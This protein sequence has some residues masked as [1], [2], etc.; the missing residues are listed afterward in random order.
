MVSDRRTQTFLHLFLVWSTTAVAV[1]MLGFGLLAAGW[2]GGAGVTVPLFLLGVPLMVGLLA[3]SGLPVRTVVPMCATGMRRLGWAVLVF[4]I[5]TL[6]VLAG[7]AAYSGD[8][9]LG[10]AGTRFALTG[11]PYTVAAAFFVPGRGVRLGAVAVLVA[12]VV[13]GGFVGPA[14]SE[15]HRHEAEIA[16]YREHPELLYLGA[17]PSGLEVSR[18]V[19]GP[20]YFSVDY[21]ADRQDE[22][23]YVGLTVRSLLMPGAGCSEIAE[24]GVTCT[25]DTH[26]EMRTVRDLPGGGHDVTLVRG[27]RNVEV[28]V[29]SQTLGEA[30]LRRILNTLHPLSDTELE[31][32]MREKKIDYVF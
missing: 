28:A 6:G 31:D 5:G 16:R 3:V 20:A 13:Y 26:G 19:V 8:V 27:H 9:D 18:A 10:S 25:V 7:L 15:R 32:L 21:R 29:T 24:K 30:G 12:G 17:A 1:P 11:V 2:S 23:A 14:Q 22:F 4:T